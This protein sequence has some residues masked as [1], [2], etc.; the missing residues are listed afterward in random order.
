MG[1]LVP[2]PAELDGYRQYLL[3]LANAR[4]DPAMRQHVDLSGIVQESLLHACQAWPRFRGQSTASRLKWLRQI[5]ANVLAD[6]LR[7]ARCGKRDITCQQSLEEGLTQSSAGLGQWLAAPRNS[8]SA[9]ICREERAVRVAT[10]LGQLPPA[11]REALL[12][13]YWHGWSLSSI[14][15]HL[16]RSPSAVAGL[17]KRGL[18]EMRV[19]LSGMETL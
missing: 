7:A 6:A 18:Q 13:H 10:A 3:M 12:L 17:L 15:E 4:L 5:L 9:A 2:G 14:G 11:Q 19:L 1:S 8:P 16:Q